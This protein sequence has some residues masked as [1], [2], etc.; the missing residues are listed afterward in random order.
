MITVNCV[1]LDPATAASLP[2]HVIINQT[3]GANGKADPPFS[4]SFVELYN[5]TDTAVSL[6]GWSIQYAQ[7][8]ST[9]NKLNLSGTIAARASFLIRAD[10]GTG[11]FRAT[12]STYDL[13]WPSVAIN[14]GTYKIALVGNQTALTV[15]N[16]TAAQGVVDLVGV[17]GADG[18]ETSPVIGGISKNIAAR[19]LN[20]SD[21]DDN[22]KDFEIVDYRV[23]NDEKNQGI[24]DA[25]FAEVRPRSAVDGQWGLD[26]VPPDFGGEFGPAN[27]MLIYQAYGRAATT[28]A[29]VSHS[30]VELYNPTD[31]AIS[32][33]GWSI[34]YATSGT[35]WTKYSLPAVAV[36]AHTSYLIRGSTAD[37]TESS[38][39]YAITAPD[40]DLPTW[41]IANG[42]FKLALVSNDTTLT[43]ANPAA[44]EGVVDLLG[45][46]GADWY[47]GLGPCASLSKQKSARRESNIDTDQNRDDFAIF[48]YNTMTYAEIAH[49]RPRSL[50]DG[51]WE[52]SEFVDP[53]E[54][55][56]FSQPAG[57]YTSNVSLELS[58]TYPG[59]V[60]RYTLDGENP[61]ASSPVYSAPLV[62]QD[63]TT[64]AELL[65]R[66][67]G[68]YTNF[69]GYHYRDLTSKTYTIPSLGT[70]F[71]GTVV[72]AQ[73]FTTSGSPMSDIIINSYIVGADIFERYKMPV[74]SISTPKANLIDPDIGLFVTGSNY[75]NQAN[76]ANFNHPIGT[77][78][79][80]DWE[81]PV[82]FEMFETDGTAVVS[83]GMGL[84]NHGGWSRDTPQK[85]LR[86][87]A[88][89][90]A[91][92]NGMPVIGG[93][94]E[95]YYDLFQG[96][97]LD[98]NGQPIPSY[99]R[100]LLRN[101][102]NDFTESLSDDAIISTIL[103]EY[104]EVET[105]AVRPVVAFINGEFWGMYNLRER[106]DDEYLA[107]QFGLSKSLFTILENDSETTVIQLSEGT[108]ADY[109]EF[110]DK[111]TEVNAMPSPLSAAN[112]AYVESIVDIE[113]IIDYVIIESYF[114]NSDSVNNSNNQR[115]FRYKGTPQ[116]G[117]PGLDGRYR[118]M[119]YDM[120][121]TYG[122]S[123]KDPSTFA[124]KGYLEFPF[125]GKLWTNTDFRARF[126]QRYC[127][128]INTIFLPAYT[129]AKTTAFQA[130]Q[131]E[132]VPEHK[133]RWSFAPTL[134]EYQNALNN[135]R[136]WQ[137][138]RPATVRNRLVT[139]SG[140]TMQN[141][142][143][144]NDRAAE[145]T[146]GQ[147][148]LNGIPLGEFLAAGTGNT[149]R[150]DARYL[151]GNTV[152]VEA[153]PDEGYRFA[154]YDVTVNGTT[155]VYTTPV[156]NLTI[157]AATTIQ[158]HYAL[159]VDPP[160]TT[161]DPYY[162]DTYFDQYEL[163]AGETLTAT[164][165]FTNSNPA[166]AFSGRVI[167]ALYSGNRMKLMTQQLFTC[168]AGATS[169][170]VTSQITLPNPLPAGAVLKAFV[171]DNNNIPVGEATIFTAAEAP[172]RP[173]PYAHYTF[174]Q[175]GTA[176]DGLV[177]PNTEGTAGAATLLVGSYG[178]ASLDGSALTLTNT[179]N[180][181]NPG[182][183]VRLPTGMLNGIDTATF[184]FYVKQDSSSSADAYFT[185][186]IYNSAGVG[187]NATNYLVFNSVNR[188]KW[189]LTSSGYSSEQGPDLSA[190]TNRNVWVHYVIV[191]TPTSI[192]MYVDGQ[193]LTTTTVSTKLSDLGT[194]LLFELG[195][196]PWNSDPLFKGSF[197]DVR[198]YDQALNAA[199]VTKLY[200]EVVSGT[201]ATGR[202]PA[203]LVADWQALQ[204]SQPNGATLTADLVLPATGANG[205][206]IFWSASNA[207]VLDSNGHITRGAA[208]AQAG[209]VATLIY[210]TGEKV[211][212]AFQY[213]VAAAG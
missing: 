52:D 205:S 129:Q 6:A 107:H 100:F 32:L 50:A 67:T 40:L 127:D 51:A 170:V 82:Y 57:L 119:L 36:P 142:T 173:T 204:P 164:T 10:A 7:S 168:P 148:D 113:S 22:S 128:L 147:L 121:N 25:K 27:H 4:H 163:T 138:S 108:D 87:Y 103:A 130:I 98:A 78:D 207:D 202:L 137:S 5:P 29:A 39:R 174:D 62:M 46:Q 109:Q 24:T 198:V 206:T 162:G 14:N 177:I 212:K 45:T 126:Y 41:Q 83:Q 141:V 12:I 89:S 21:I 115:F 135:R 33:A 95:V 176:S 73:L 54:P 84:R 131:T 117:V 184:S 8:G 191:Q 179:S 17:D 43:V 169:Q 160:S 161:A 1:N 61:T 71:K 102:G 112:Y 13:D 28:A 201:G 37:A 156:I 140:A 158:A 94:S 96:A 35:T 123:F 150:L 159:D 132:A 185:A 80:A 186:G 81:R 2:T 23:R 165:Y 79:G 136:S 172:N 63:R 134:T 70:V 31:T 72:K 15:A 192:T 143:I 38:I 66:T 189:R 197:G 193:L 97:A 116:P 188:H 155:T 178:G 152:R 200:Q 92:D 209:L 19:R 194:N 203:G 26:L 145:R 133:A 3:Y 187:S 16:P 106:Y 69:A 146:F 30:F 77:E 99:K 199:A 118:W 65:S 60:I 58:T 213:T 180:R 59:T 122:G 18:S 44:A 139:L 42:T 124:N 90:G 85:T 144:I 171:W 153:T 208:A 175:T 64:D 120:D 181:Q 56:T 195:R 11:T 76:T 104:S 166:T 55:I 20:F 149:D 75:T 182:A 125:F 183:Y 154:S 74:I 68:T 47:E 210:P 190:S 111:A 151:A 110:I 167:L 86:L 196:G 91:L 48:G 211:T 9:W 101:Y 93:Q 49:Y 88:R 157:S 53:G 105:Q 34:Q 114:D